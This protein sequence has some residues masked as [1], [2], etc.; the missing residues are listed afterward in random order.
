[1]RL[2]MDEK[3][4]RPNH[5]SDAGKD[6]SCEDFQDRMPELMG[7]DIYSHEHLKT[8]TRCSALLEDLQ[9]IAD[10]ARA[11]MQDRDYEPSDAL[12]TKIESKMG[13]DDLGTDS[14]PPLSEPAS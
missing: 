2:I 8:C 13:A 6:M 3:V 9:A 5:S 7:G 14:H 10:A 11:F 1:M 12:W 4:D